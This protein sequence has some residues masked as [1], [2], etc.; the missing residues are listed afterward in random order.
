MELMYR[1][2]D[3]KEFDN[4]ADAC[5]HENYVINQMVYMFDPDG[6]R[7]YSTP[8]AIVILLNGEEAA[9]TFLAL[10]KRQNHEYDGCNGISDGAEGIWFWDDYEKIYQHLPIDVEEAM[11]SALTAAKMIEELGEDA[12][13]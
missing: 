6:K 11:L 5:Y 4:E 13:V 12:N 9:S 10:E 8:D 3:G 2:I 1:T 7:V